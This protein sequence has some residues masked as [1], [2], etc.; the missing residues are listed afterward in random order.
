VQPRLEL[1]VPLCC[2]RCEEKVKESLLDMDGEPLVLY[3][4]FLCIQLVFY[5]I[6]LHISFSLAHL[7]VVKQFLPVALIMSTFDRWFA[8]FEIWLMKVMSHKLGNQKY[9]SNCYD[10]D[11]S[12]CRCGRGTMRSVAPEGDDNRKCATPESA[13]TCE[14][15][16]EALW[17]LDAWVSCPAICRRL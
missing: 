10:C 15:S 3:W 8:F 16:Q 4:V 6:L 14:E 5:H 12:W 9:H 17:F 2:E 13:S 1:K 7:V 11:W